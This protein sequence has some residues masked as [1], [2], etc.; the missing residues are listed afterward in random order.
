MSKLDELSG[1]IRQGSDNP[2]NKKKVITFINRKRRESKE[3]G[4]KR[5]F[6]KRD[7]KK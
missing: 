5:P 1:R 2:F 6:W 7:W 4:R 3:D